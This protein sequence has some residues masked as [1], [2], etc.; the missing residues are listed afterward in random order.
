MLPAQSQQWRA[1][2]PVLQ[3][4]CDTTLHVLEGLQV[5]EGLG[6]WPWLQGLQHEG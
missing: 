2:G 3:E 6:V 1:A 4:V 5:V